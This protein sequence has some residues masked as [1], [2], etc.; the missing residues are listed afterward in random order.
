MQTLIFFSKEHEKRWQHGRRWGLLCSS[1]NRFIA[2]TCF[3]SR[4][5]SWV[6]IGTWQT[7]RR[8]LIKASGEEWW[9]PSDRVTRV[10]ARWR[11]FF[12]FCS[13]LLL[14]WNLVSSCSDLSKLLQEMQHD[15]MGC[16]LFPL[17]SMFPTLSS[18]QWNICLW[19]ISSLSDVQDHHGLIGI[20]RLGSLGSVTRWSVIIS[21]HF[22]NANSSSHFL[23]VLVLSCSHLFVKTFFSR[24]DT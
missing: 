7:T 6:R 18:F 2:Q 12:L 14:V 16:V 1:F 11:C 23:C 21:C 5:G 15:G 8:C 20:V 17:N 10:H 19:N 3:S 13:L 4:I 24:Y 9:Q 22:F